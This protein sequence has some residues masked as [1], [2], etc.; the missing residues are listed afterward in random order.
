MLTDGGYSNAEVARCEDEA[1]TASAPIK[2]GAMNSERFRPTEFHYDETSDT[3]RCPAGQNL[4]P[5]GRRT[6]EPRCPLPDVRL[7]GLSAEGAMHLRR[8][9]D[10][11]SADRPRR[12]RSDAAAHLR[13]SQPDEDQAMISAVRPFG[14]PSPAFAGEGSARPPTFVNAVA[15][16]GEGNPHSSGSTPFLK[17]KQP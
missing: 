7:Q 12:P 6:R 17:M 2:R 8:S 10:H 13:R 5:W 9:A 15:Q 3:I 1:I 16:A 4:R 14:P 11:P